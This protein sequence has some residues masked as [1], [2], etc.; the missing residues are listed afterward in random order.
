MCGAYNSLQPTECITP[1]YMDMLYKVLIQQST[2][3]SL[4]CERLKPGNLPAGSQ[5]MRR[6]CS[7]ANVGGS[8]R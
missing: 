2:P 7:R 3:T 8:E 1:N 5:R 4:I 6:R